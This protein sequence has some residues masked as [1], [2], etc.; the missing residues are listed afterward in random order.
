LTNQ[1]KIYTFAFQLNKMAGRPKIFDEAQAVQNATN[2]FWEKGFDATSTDEL[3]RE[4]GLQRGSFYHSFGSKKD[5]FIN[6]FMRYETMSF[7]ELQ[8]QL[9]ASKKPM[10][11]IKS[12]FYT[13][14]K[15]S[16]EEHNK[17]CFAGNTITALS[18]IDAELTEIANNHLKKMENIF[19]EQIKSSQ[20]SGELTTKTDARL[21][22]MS[23]I[24]LWN[25]LNITR[26]VYT[27]KKDLKALV[28]FQLAVLV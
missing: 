20:A 18:N 26:K 13:L 12:I 3:M 28:D 25:G 10:N 8:R 9:K 7:A 23:L 27:S 22:S 19:F 4:M 21:L 1:Y 14:A 2:L 24:N 6:A 11:V 15:C 17:G 16:L 5:L